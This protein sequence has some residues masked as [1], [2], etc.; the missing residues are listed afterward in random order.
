MVLDLSDQPLSVLFPVLLAAGIVVWFAATRI[1]A[2][3][4]A[5]ARRT[6]IGQAFAGMLLLGGVTSLPEVATAGTAAATGNPLLRFN[7]V[8]GGASM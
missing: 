4:D 7:D 2:Y 3:I 5:I 1:V 6:H 8:L